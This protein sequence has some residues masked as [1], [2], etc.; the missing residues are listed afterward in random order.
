M[1]KNW[2]DADDDKRLAMGG[3]NGRCSG[4][5]LGWGNGNQAH[6]YTME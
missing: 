4:K 6:A 2:M 5:L 1:A 3:L